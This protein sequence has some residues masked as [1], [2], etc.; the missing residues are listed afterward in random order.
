MIEFDGLVAPTVGEALRDDGDTVTVIQEAEHA[1]LLAPRPVRPLV[2]LVLLEK[3]SG[4]RD[5][6]SRQ[7]LDA[8]LGLVGALL[9]GGVAALGDESAL[10]GRQPSGSDEAQS[11]RRSPAR[12]PIPSP[13]CRRC[14]G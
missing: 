12:L 14:R 5:E 8:R 3:L 13:T 7:L 11:D 1:R 6:P 9:G 4:G 10:L 2:A